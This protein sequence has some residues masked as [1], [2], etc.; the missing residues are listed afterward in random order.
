MDAL[1]FIEKQGKVRRQPFYVLSGDEDN[2]VPNAL[3]VE[4]ANNIHN[5]KLVILPDCGHLPQPEQ[6][7]AT[8]KALIEW[9]GN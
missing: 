4:M 7:E 9:L 2:T 3:S 6:P 5:A 8:A 1:A